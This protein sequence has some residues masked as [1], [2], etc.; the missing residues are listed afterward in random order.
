[1]N[2]SQ[3][4]YRQILKFTSLFGGVQVISVLISIV[5]SKI[6]AIL[7]GT[8][9]FGIYGLFNS[10]MNLIL[11]FSK[12]GLDV[13]AVKEISAASGDNEI[14]KIFRI[15]NIL[16]RLIWITG[17]IGAIVTI[18]LSPWLSELVFKN[19]DYISAF[20][21]IS[22]A[23]FF[24]QLTI[25]NLA[26]LQGLRK[27]KSLAKSTVIASFCSLIVTVPL[28]YFLG[29]K[30]IVPVIVLT[31]LFA[32]LCSWYFTK[33]QKIPSEI[34]SVRKV[35]E[36]G[37]QMIKLGFV[38]SIGGIVTVLGTF[39]MQLF[40]ENYAG[41]EEVG[42]YNAAFIIISA[43]VGVIFNAMSKDYFPRLASIANQNDVL[44][45]VVNQQSFI[46]VLLITPVIV[47]FLAF[48][49]VIVKI[50][51]NKEFLPIIGLLTFGILATL[52]KAVS[53]AIAYV[54]I[55]K[56]NSKLF[57]KTEIIFNILLLIMS[58]FGYYYGGLT[59][60]GLSYLLY[61]VIYLVSIK[62]VVS[63]NYKF[64]FQEEFYKIFTVCLLLC[65]VTY[66]ITYIENDYIKYGLMIIMIISSCIFTIIKLN[67]KLNLKESLEKIISKHK[68]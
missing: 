59:G 42:L 12:L 3:K 33:K 35:F 34:I 11:G 26:I 47:V 63:Y 58:V 68:K 36:E 21:F 32:F 20:I 41:L 55:A 53:W 38:L 22:F 61:F 65:L 16:K 6:A 48:M 37:K 28:Y 15:V 44:N 50:L 40:L 10:A 23:V 9:G 5:K 30:G 7:I 43:Y 24:N 46:T 51:L 54:L 66:T 60:V 64:K 57:I 18:V 45:T 4:S 56:G 8:A 52:F 2:E 14:E 67:E 1:M 29:V 19:D 49:P 27:L 39:L 17:I 13:S 31:A 62:K 25:G